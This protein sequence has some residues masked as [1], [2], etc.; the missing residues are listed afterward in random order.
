MT[1]IMFIYYF[2]VWSRPQLQ[3]KKYVDILGEMACTGY[4][5]RMEETI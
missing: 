1:R 2:H 5:T 4:W 3:L